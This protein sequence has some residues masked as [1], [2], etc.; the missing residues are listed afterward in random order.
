M[1]K[2]VDFV[3]GNAPFSPFL[4]PKCCPLWTLDTWKKPNKQTTLKHVFS[5][6]E[7]EM[8]VFH[9]GCPQVLKDEDSAAVSVPLSLGNYWQ[10]V[11]SAKRSS[12]LPFPEPCHATFQPH[13]DRMLMMLISRKCQGAVCFLSCNGAFKRKEGGVLRL[14]DY[15]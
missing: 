12:L 15:N 8:K 7:M 3:R 1:Q 10:L 6:G 9:P 14:L 4:I 2:F 13:N 11:L 5:S